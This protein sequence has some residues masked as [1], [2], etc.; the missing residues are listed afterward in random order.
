MEFMGL[1]GNQ[2]ELIRQLQ[3]E[4]SLVGRYSSLNCVNVIGSQRR[5][6]L[7]IVFQGHDS[8]RDRLVAIKVM[9]PDRLGDAY[10][11]SAFEREPDLLQQLEGRSRCLQLIS[12]LEHYTWEINPPDVPDPLQIKCGFFV[13][14]WLEE[15]VDEYFYDQQNHKAS[16]KLEIFREILLAVE[17]VH[18][19]DIFHRDIKVDNIRVKPTNGSSVSVLIDFGTAAHLSG[20]PLESGYCGPVGAP[21]FSPPEAFV[22]FSGDRKLGKLSDSYAPGALLFNLF[23]YRDFLY[24]RE[25]E[26]R[27]NQL[28][29]SIIPLIALE[30][31]RDNKLRKWQEQMCKFRKLSVT[32]EIAGPGNTLPSAASRIIKQAYSGLI[33]FDFLQRVGDLPVTRRHIDTAIRVLSNQKRQETDLKRKRDLRKRRQEKIRQK[34]ERLDMFISQRVLNHA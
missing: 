19:A 1:S 32:P 27:F 14:E 24:V 3:N 22:G 33:D 9:D 18:R 16:V 26:T 28:R 29:S 6:V 10:R 8:V 13:A 2:K 25:N 20:A 4:S 12:G 17:A 31:S 21:A 5:G 11:I 34:Q 7:S 30:S 23:N 15:D